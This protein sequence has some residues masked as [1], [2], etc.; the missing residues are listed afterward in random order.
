MIK[1]RSPMAAP[2]NAVVKFNVD[3]LTSATTYQISVDGGSTFAAAQPLVSGQPIGLTDGAG[4]LLW[5]MSVSGTPADGDV[6]QVDPTPF[7]AGNNGNALALAALRDALL[8]DGATVTDRWAS[9]LSDIGVRVQ[10]ADGAAQL[11]GAVAKDAEARNSAKSGV[12]LDE[13]AA[14]LIQYQ[15]SYQAAAKMLQVAQSV[16]D[17]LLQVTN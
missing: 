4:T 16:F 13:E 5:Q 15:Q 7:A 14:R 6:V 9:A 10:S 2:A 11:S 3:P 12:N 1:V 17:T 8:V